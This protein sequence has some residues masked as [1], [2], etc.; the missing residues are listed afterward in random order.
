MPCAKITQNRNEPLLFTFH[1]PSARATTPL[2]HATTRHYERDLCNLL[3]PQAHARLRKP[4]RP[5]PLHS[6]SAH[7]NTLPHARIRPDP[8]PNVHLPFLSTTHTQPSTAVKTTCNHT[9]H[10]PTP[11]TYEPT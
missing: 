8:I 4:K 5:M 10:T 3:F 1:Y 7:A 2:R 11:E 6:I 9:H